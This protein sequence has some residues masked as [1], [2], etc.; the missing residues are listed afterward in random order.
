MHITPKI[1][2][3]RINQGQKQAGNLKLETQKIIIKNIIKW[4]TGKFSCTFC[5]CIFARQVI[6][7]CVS[8][9][10]KT[11]LVTPC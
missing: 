9:E 10:I 2:Y 6:S 5:L 4:V 11:G 7:V 1:T 3:S 8:A